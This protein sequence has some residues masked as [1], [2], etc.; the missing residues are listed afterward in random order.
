M[1][2]TKIT[3]KEANSL[4]VGNSIKIRSWESM[5]REYSVSSADEIKITDNIRYPKSCA[6]HCEKTFKITKI[7]DTDDGLAF[8]T[9]GAGW[10]YRKMIECAFITEETCMSEICMSEIDFNNLQEGDSIQVRSWD[11]MVKEYSLDRDGDILIDEGAC[12]EFIKADKGECGRVFIVD[13]IENE[14]VNTKC[15][16]EFTRQMLEP[17]SAKIE[18]P[19]KSKTQKEIGILKDLLS[20]LEEIDKLEIDNRKLSS[21]KSANLKRIADIKQK[22]NECKGNG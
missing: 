13:E 7:H 21:Q 11:S 19:K 18:K 12:S 4:K 1:A 22:Y 10:I 16:T 8:D 14:F 9:N 3:I 20:M 2:R 17:R 6:S 15:D 5:A